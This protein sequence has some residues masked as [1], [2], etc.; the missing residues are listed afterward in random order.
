[1]GNSEWPGCCVCVCWKL[2]EFTFNYW[3]CGVE[4]EGIEISVHLRSR[5]LN[6][7]FM[8]GRQNQY[9][10]TQQHTYKF[11]HM[12]IVVCLL[13]RPAAQ[14][15]SPYRSPVSH[16]ASCHQ[17]NLTAERISLGGH[18]WAPHCECVC[19]AFHLGPNVRGFCTSA[20]RAT[21][22]QI[23]AANQHR[24]AQKT[25]VVR[26]SW[27]YLHSH[28]DSKSVGHRFYHRQTNTAQEDTISHICF[29]FLFY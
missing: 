6:R 16:L 10:C 15:S 26:G 29:F 9:T 24:T 19:C 22:N 14:K 3:W 17:P 23:A 8:G 5:Y 12:R 11:S 20:L 1:M 21:P 4:D 18:R 13:A 28:S 2:I 27:V 25:T 7:R